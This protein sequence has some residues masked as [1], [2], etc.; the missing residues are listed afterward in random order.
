MKIKELSRGIGRLL[1]LWSIVSIAVGV[2][3]NISSPGTLVG[4]IGLQAIIWGAID[5]VIAAYILVKQKEQSITKVARTVYINLYLDIVYQIVG[6]FVIVILYRNPYFVG[7]GI[8]IIIQGFFLLLL[9]LNYYNS[10]R[11]L[12]KETIAAT[13]E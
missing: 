13:N 11:D 1:S 9:D 2:V 7:N 12:E 10:L 4:G 5:A 6:F 3:L 8:G